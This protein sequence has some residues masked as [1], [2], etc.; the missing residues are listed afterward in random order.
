MP[1]GPGKAFLL[2]LFFPL[3]FLAAAVPLRAHPHMFIDSRVELEFDGNG[4]K[5]F[6]VEWLFDQFFTAQI[7]LDYDRDRDGRLDKDEVSAVERG[8]FS[9][10]V[11]YHYFTSVE[12]GGKRHDVDQ[13]SGFDAF[14][15][16]GRLGYRFYIPC[17]A[18]APSAGRETG[19]VRISIFDSTFF[20]D[21]AYAGKDPVS[22]RAP[23]GLSADW[24]ILRNTDAPIIY[25]PASGIARREG[26]SYTGTV[27]PEELRVLFSTKGD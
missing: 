3:L 1:F 27:Y 21:I 2:P 19:E 8:A 5:G 7:L 4:M 13:V 24:E 10:L 20:C 17:K 16:D 12:T 18:P 22:V 25:D 9:N 14:I 11:H 6:T 23:A 26:D 15:R